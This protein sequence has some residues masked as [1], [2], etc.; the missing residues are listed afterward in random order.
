MNEKT[1]SWDDLYLF[2]AVAREGG[3]SPAARVTGPMARFERETRGPEIVF[4]PDGAEVWAEGP[5]RS[6]ALSA[7]GAGRLRWYQHGVPV[8]LDAGGQSLWQPEGPGFYE[9]T[10]VDEAG[11][12]ARTRVRVR[13]PAS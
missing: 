8:A 2:L 6:F 10:V 11:R 1:A 7:R 5:Q 9:L 4:P 3:L 12:S 13:V